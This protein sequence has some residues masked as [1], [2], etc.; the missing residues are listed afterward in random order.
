M[1]RGLTL[2][3]VSVAL[4]IMG[5]V[6]VPA[7]YTLG[8]ATRSSQAAARDERGTR[9]ARQLLAEVVQSPYE[10]AVN[11]VFGREFESSANRDGW[12]DVD[13]YHGWSSSPPESKD[14][15]PMGEFD[16][17][18]RQVAVSYANP[19]TLAASGSFTDTGLKLITVT[20]TSPD[21]EVTTLR[22]V[23]ARSGAYDQ[24]PAMNTVYLTWVG[25]ELRTSPDGPTD[26]DGVNL[27]NPISK[28][29]AP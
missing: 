9:L 2:V 23:R 25:V 29:A 13:D 19:G 6:L 22:A 7:L 12:D 28:G 11:P 26:A 16:G 10:E 24:T 1:R 17:W 21:S 27:R 8:S 14:G 20:V 18:T 5:V 4:V 15:T 3:E